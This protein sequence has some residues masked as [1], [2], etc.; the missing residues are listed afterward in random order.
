MNILTRL[1]SRPE[2]AAETA[3]T[4]FD[5]LV[6]RIVAPNPEA[7]ADFIAANK[8]WP[9]ILLAGEQIARRLS[10]APT[11][12]LQAALNRIFD[13]MDPADVDGLLAVVDDAARQGAKQRVLGNTWSTFND[14]HGPC[15]VRLMREF[16]NLRTGLTAEVGRM[17]ERAR[18]ELAR[19]TPLEV[20]RMRSKA[21]TDLME[22]GI[23]KKDSGAAVPQ[24]SPVLVRWAS[25][26]EQ[27]SELHAYLRGGRRGDHIRGAAEWYFATVKTLEPITR[28]LPPTLEQ[29]AA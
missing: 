10:P 7:F 2:D 21:Q 18:A 25:L 20:E 6:C 27:L 14:P 26:V 15:L 17:I 9:E 12:S 1:W 4:S 13:S 22:C 8:R 19:I 5:E 11:Y 24:E 3:P 23:A 16:P 28:N 29:L